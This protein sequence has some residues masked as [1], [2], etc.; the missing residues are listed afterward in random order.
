ME[1]W[2]ELMPGLAA[3]LD[4]DRRILAANRRFV[5][6]VGATGLPRLLGFRPGEA[7]TCHHANEHP[8][9]CGSSPDCA[10]CGVLGAVAECRARGKQV[11][12]VARILTR[13][14]NDGGAMDC[15]V[16]AAP[17]RLQD[18]DCTVVCIEDTGAEARRRLLEGALLEPLARQCQEARELLARLQADAADA[19]EGEAATRRLACLVEGM[20]DRLECQRDLLAAETG[21]LAVVVGTFGVEALLAELA[22]WAR[23]QPA[24]AGRTL[25]LEEVAP[26]TVS[27]DRRLLRRV[28]GNLVINALEASRPGETVT[29][30]CRPEERLLRFRVGNP[31][32]IPRPVR[33]G[34][35]QRS[36][37]THSEPG[38]GTGLFFARM[39]TQFY[40]DGEIGYRSDAHH[41]TVFEVG[42][43]R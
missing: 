29:L 18:R 20:R 41:G 13:Q 4:A 43:P 8:E 42:I 24:A 27:T 26:G 33:A 16:H 21:D 1:H 15:R 5:K 2:I 10:Y 3:V 37:T 22:G 39:L 36:F 12:K 38:R 14:A 32:V 7:L 25:S 19:G 31:G 35:F 6:A 23:A 34:L 30:A 17:L 9:G 11:T 28:L 40:L